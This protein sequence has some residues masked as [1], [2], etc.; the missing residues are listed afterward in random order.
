MKIVLAFPPSKLFE[1]SRALRKVGDR[2]KES[3]ELSVCTPKGDFELLF[4]VGNVGC[5]DGDSEGRQ[6]GGDSDGVVCNA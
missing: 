3:V 2:K 4:M 1:L 6:D 5:S